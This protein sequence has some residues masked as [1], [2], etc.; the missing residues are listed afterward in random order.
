[1]RI[2][3]DSHDLLMPTHED[4]HSE[5]HQLKEQTFTNFISNDSSSM[6]EMWLRMV[7]ISDGLGDVLQLHYRIKGPEPSM[8]EVDQLSHH[9]DELKLRDKLDKYNDFLKAHGLQIE[10]L[11][12]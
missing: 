9:L 10:L 12:E 4:V 2:R 8:E 11:Y 5:L 1:M 7:R 3:N 6:T